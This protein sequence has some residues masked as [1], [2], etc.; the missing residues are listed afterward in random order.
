MKL[1][2]IG[3]I[4]EVS[5]RKGFA[6]L[7]VAAR[8]NDEGFDFVR[9][10]PGV[11]PQRP[12][13]FEALVDTR[14]L[15]YLQLPP[16]PLVRMKYAVR[17]GNIVRDHLKRPDFMRDAQ[18]GPEGLRG[19]HIIDTRTLKRTFVRTL[20]ADQKKL[21]AYGMPTFVGLLAIIETGLPTEEWDWGLRKKPE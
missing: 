17:A 4:L 20:S 3:E 13:D 19:W 18:F 16:G 11:F 12:S 1:I 15:C 8:G 21:S 2:P 7:H 14:E 9:V 6:Y 10:L 5:T